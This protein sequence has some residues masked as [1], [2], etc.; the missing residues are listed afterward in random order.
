MNLADLALTMVDHFMFVEGDFRPA[1]SSLLTPS[2]CESWCFAVQAGAACHQGGGNGQSF[3][4]A[5]SAQS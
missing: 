2:K 4:W 5:H 1:A 3:E